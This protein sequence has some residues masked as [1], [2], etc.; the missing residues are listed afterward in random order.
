MNKAEHDDNLLNVDVR[1]VPENEEAVERYARDL[2]WATVAAR[3]VSIYE[4]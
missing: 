1:M 2:W 3:D 4:W